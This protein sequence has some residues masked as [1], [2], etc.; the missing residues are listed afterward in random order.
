[1][2]CV[3]LSTDLSN[4]FYMNKLSAPSVTL[5]H[6][7]NKGHFV[8]MHKQ[9]SRFNFFMFLFK[10]LNNCIQFHDCA[11]IQPCYKS[12]MYRKTQNI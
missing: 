6:F 1:M 10:F 8:V 3:Q 9:K 7:N 4:F 11:H 5:M 2:A 12:E